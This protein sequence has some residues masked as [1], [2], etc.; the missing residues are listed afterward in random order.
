MA[1]VWQGLVGAAILCVAAVAAWMAQRVRAHNS[2]IGMLENRVIAAE[3]SEK[4]CHE[5]M[6][7][8]RLQNLEAEI[9]LA[10]LKEEVTRLTREVEAL[11]VRLNDLPPGSL[12]SK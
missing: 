12:T 6:R 7:Q 5:Q 11:H 4:K 1:D 9:Q 10:K 2:F 8:L 3:E